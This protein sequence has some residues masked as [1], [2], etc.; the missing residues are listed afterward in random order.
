MFC[1][2]L[3]LRKNIFP[4]VNKEGLSAVG[5]V[6]RLGH[7]ALIGTQVN[8]QHF[9]LLYPSELNRFLSPLSQVGIQ[10]GIGETILCTS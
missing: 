4:R 3:R 5:R 8:D 1:C 10:Q 6:A 2:G 9:Q 7:T